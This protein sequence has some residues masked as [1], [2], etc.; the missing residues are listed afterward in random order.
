MVKTLNDAEA[1]ELRGYSLSSMEGVIWSLIPEPDR[2]L[3]SGVSSSLVDGVTPGHRRG[4]LELTE[5]LPLWK[6]ISP[7]HICREM[8]SFQMNR[9]IRWS[10]SAA[11]LLH[12]LFFLWCQVSVLLLI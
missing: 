1:R 11:I 3:S 9:E 12:I 10:Q 2:H 4:P 7:P 8:L 5:Q 6:W